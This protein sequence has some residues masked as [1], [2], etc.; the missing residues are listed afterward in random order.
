[1]ERLPGFGYKTR[2]AIAERLC[3]EQIDERPV[4]ERCTVLDLRKAAT[5]EI[6]CQLLDARVGKRLW[7]LV[8]GEDD[9]PVVMT[10]DYPAQITV[11]DSFGGLDSWD[12]VTKNIRSLTLHLVERLEV[13]WSPK[14]GTCDLRANEALG[15]TA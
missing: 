14:T 8:H 4:E 6:M 3:L 2:V 15:G 13:R 10:P 7:A 1:M 5:E 11:E 9:Q 12:E